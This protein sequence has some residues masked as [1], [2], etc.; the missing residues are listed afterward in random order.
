LKVAVQGLNF[1]AH[2]SYIQVQVF[3]FPFLQLFRIKALRQSSESWTLV[4]RLPGVGDV[5]GSFLFKL[6]VLNSVWILVPALLQ[7]V[8]R[9]LCNKEFAGVLFY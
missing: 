6:R 5:G 1:M 3:D 2:L 9:E 4:F 8:C 7:L